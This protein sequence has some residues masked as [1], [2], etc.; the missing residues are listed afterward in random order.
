MLFEA[1]SYF[2]LNWKDYVIIDKSLFRKKEIYYSKANIYQL[3][4]D[5]GYVPSING[6]KI[7]R[8][9]I[10][11]YLKKIYRNKFEKDLIN[12]NIKK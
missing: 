6:L 5:I 12:Q 10:K 9:L 1:F 11:Y 8:K 4:K 7:V 3:K 2:K